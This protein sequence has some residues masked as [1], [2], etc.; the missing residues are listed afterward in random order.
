MNFSTE[1]QY[2]GVHTGATF[3]IDSQTVD[4]NF[5]HITFVF[6]SSKTGN[7][8][9]F[10]VRLDGADVAL[11]FTGSVDATTSASVSTFYGKCN[12]DG[13]TA[14]FIG[15]IAECLIWTRALNG[16]EV[17]AVEHYIT[18]KWVV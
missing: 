7:A 3:T 8:N 18:N 10:K 13:T 11:P 1:I 6:D 5:H 17:S 12:A 9:R 15:D 16:S 4:T 2:V 14:D